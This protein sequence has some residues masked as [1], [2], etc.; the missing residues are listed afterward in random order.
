MSPTGPHTSPLTVPQNLATGKA[1]GE[2]FTVSAESECV[3]HSLEHFLLT[4]K[5]KAW[6]WGSPIYHQLV[7][8]IALHVQPLQD[9]LGQAWYIAVQGNEAEGVNAGARLWEGWTYC[10]YVCGWDVRHGSHWWRFLVLSPP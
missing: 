5:P 1:M 2:C 3:L 8:F 10:R 7:L 4:S 6:H 9:P